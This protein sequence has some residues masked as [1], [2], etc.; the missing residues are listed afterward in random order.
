MATSEPAP[1]YP[2]IHALRAVAATLVVIEHA[3]FVANDYSLFGISLIVPHFSY[4]RIG[5]I[6]FFA[7][8]G[9]VIALQRTKPAGEFIV[10]RLLRIY[11]SYWIAILLSAAAF[12]SV[13]KHISASPASILLYPSVTSDDAL[14]IP[15]W[16]LVFEV[17]FYALA[18][19]A[20]AAKLSDRTLTLLAVAW[21][22]AVNLFAADPASAVEYSLPGPTILLSPAV[23]VFPMGLICGLHFGALRRAGRWPYVVA[24]IV[25]YVA[26]IAFAELSVAKILM[27]GISSACLIVAVADL[28]R[29]CRKT[30]EWFGDA[31][32]GIYLIHFPVLLAVVKLSPDHRFLTLFSI[33]LALGITFGRF[34][35]WLY[36]S[37]IR[38][39]WPRLAQPPQPVPHRAASSGLQ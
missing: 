21:I 20:F 36:R 25:A 32:Y 19:L 6:L 1:F 18:A 29:S 7:I 2:G 23:Q 37:M 22:V 14:A 3:A 39:L 34:D 8:S 38:K 17:T 12:A 10:H 31:S 15:Y 24:S 30:I 28:G 11:P 5:V 13:G 33:A 26:G 35:H 27:L 4:G 16:T 9:F